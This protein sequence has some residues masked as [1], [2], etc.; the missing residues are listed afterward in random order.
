MHYGK[1]R[2]TRRTF[3]LV[4]KISTFVDILGLFDQV[5]RVFD[6][7]FTQLPLRKAFWATWKYEKSPLEEKQVVSALFP[8]VHWSKLGDEGG[9]KMFG[10]NTVVNCQSGGHRISKQNRFTAHNKTLQTLAPAKHHQA[11]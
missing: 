9:D 5:E 2:G 8:L 10:P 3:I 7:Y 6:I 1:F 11:N 4:A